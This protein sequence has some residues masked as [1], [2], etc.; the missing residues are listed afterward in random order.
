MM[1][2]GLTEFYKLKNELRVKQGLSPLKEDTNEVCR[3]MRASSPPTSAADLI[4]Q[5]RPMTNR[6]IRMAKKVRL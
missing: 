1:L 5:Q 4:E 6:S 2:G 3:H